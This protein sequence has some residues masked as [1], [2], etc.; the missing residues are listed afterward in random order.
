L[1]CRPFAWYLRRF[2]AVYEDA[3]I[4]PNEI[5]MIEVGESGKCLHFQGPAGTSG[6]GSEGVD[7]RRCDASDDRFFWHLGNRNARGECCSGLRA[8]NTDQCFAGEQGGGEKGITTICDL[9]GADRRQLWVLNADGQLKKGS[10]C[11]GPGSGSK[12]LKTSRC[13]TMQS[14]VFRKVSV[15]VPVETKLYRKSQ[16]ENPEMFKKLDAQFPSSLEATCQDCV[17]LVLEKGNRCLDDHASLPK[18]VSSCTPLRVTDGLVKTRD[19]TCLDNWSDNDIET[20][21]FYDCHGGPTQQF[22]MGHEGLLCSV[23]NRECFRVQKAPG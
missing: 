18:E 19:G 23:G 8:W 4:I 21:G 17:F 14:P 13:S 11:L 5:F 22:K 9:S 7:L 3:G 6:H 12:P 20:W 15:V 16:E 1:Q 10:N 2:K